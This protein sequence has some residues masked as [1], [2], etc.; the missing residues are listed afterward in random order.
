MIEEDAGQT[1]SS[2][3]REPQRPRSSFIYPESLFLG[4]KITENWVKKSQ[5]LDELSLQFSISGQVLGLILPLSLPSFF[6]FPVFR[7][8]EICFNQV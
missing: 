7:V 2:G 5:P 6:F 3:L 8:L 4:N 1:S